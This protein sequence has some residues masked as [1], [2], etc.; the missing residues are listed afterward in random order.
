MV[1]ERKNNSKTRCWSRGSTVAPLRLLSL[2][3]TPLPRWVYVL[4][5]LLCPFN[6][7]RVSLTEK[8]GHKACVFVPIIRASVRLFGI[9]QSLAQWTTCT[10]YVFS[11]CRCNQLQY[12]TIL[13][14]HVKRSPKKAAS[15]IGIPMYD[16]QPPSLLEPLLLSLSLF[17]C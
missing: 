9:P 16:S 17:L 4:F 2:L 11:A 1:E 5:L 10:F 12:V 13:G 3:T 6:T 14:Y 15:R 7:C 8:G